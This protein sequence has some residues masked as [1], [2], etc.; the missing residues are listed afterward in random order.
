[1]AQLALIAGNTVVGIWDPITSQYI[2]TLDIEGFMP[3]T[4]ARS[5]DA[6]C[7]AIGFVGQS[8]EIWDITVN[9]CL[10]ILVA[11]ICSLSQTV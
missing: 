2:L 5:P 7:I 11:T 8:I 9:R 6:T 1:M 4:I 3:H 10:S